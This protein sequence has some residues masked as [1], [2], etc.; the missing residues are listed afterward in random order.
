MSAAARLLALLLAFAGTLATFDVEAA[1]RKGARPAPPAAEPGYA[2]AAAAYEA[3]E[4][5]DYPQ[6]VRHAEE[7][8]RLAPQRTDWQ[9]LLKNAREAQQ[10]VEAQAAG[11]AMYR[12]MAQRDWPAA[13]R[14]ARLAT[15]LAPE[16]AGYRLALVDALLHAGDYAAAEKAATE[17]LALLPDSATPLAQRAHA[18]HRLG[19]LEEA[20]SDID[21]AL[22]L[23]A[24]T[25]EDARELRLIAARPD[26]GPPV[27]DCTQVE[28]AQTCAVRAA[29]PPPDPA[30][31]AAAAGYR[32]MQAGDA[33]R[34]LQLAR[35]ATEA[36]PSNRDWQLLR[37]NAALAQGRL[38][39]AQQAGEAVK[40]LGGPPTVDLAYLAVRTGDDRAAAQTFAQADRAGAL[41][42]SSLLDAGYA[43]MR[44]H[45]DEVAA[46]YLRRAIDAN[47]SLQL[48]MD[49]QM[50]YATR[51]TLAELERKWGVLASLTWR[52]GGGALPGFGATG[53][54]AARVLQAGA[55]AYWR[56]WGF[57]NGQF[58]EVF[59]RGFETLHSEGGGATGSDSFEGALGV[60]W[61]PLT[62]H[63]AV[64]SASR[65]FGTNIAS[66]WLV[67]A[68]YSLDRGTDLRLDVAAWSTQRFSAEVGHYFGRDVTY[69]LASLQA[70]RSFR[71]GGAEGRT[72]LFPHA[73]VAA[74]YDSSL[75]Q[76][77]AVGAGPGIAVRHWFREDKYHAPR[78]YVDLTLQ[79]RVRVAGDDRA[80][81][82]YLGTQLS[83]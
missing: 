83:Y 64:L 45:D 79:Y 80:R 42:P 75:A 28:T 58:V 53:G 50:L 13:A 59:L 29:A 63:N 7:A 47:E 54:G 4:K 32:A 46:A 57:R 27:L 37:L 48:K 21:R 9:A 24:L 69:G 1:G 18:R 76:K 61:K 3:F 40:Q 78:S 35:E 68:A 73:V 12:A 44:T 8:V 67:Q 5:R 31:E 23:Q 17:A 70:G 38:D 36:Q 49:Q 71:L 65:V 10:R 22:R 33:A 52:P 74:E 72:V 39:E 41:P 2:A 62:A 19:R 56:P 16:H 6:A 26:A 82:V 60:R 34:A 14:H 55:E 11:E 51:R 43:A 81:G 25:P 15:E 66:E 77:T 30:F 20:R